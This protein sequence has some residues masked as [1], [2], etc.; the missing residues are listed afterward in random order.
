[1]LPKKS[2]HHVGITLATP[3]EMAREVELAIR[4]RRAA[5]S[6]AAI[7]VHTFIEAQRSPRYR[8]ALNDASIGWIDGVPI[9]WL[10]HA[11]GFPPPPRIHGADLFLLLLERLKDARHL[12]YGSTPETL[13]LLEQRLNERLPGIRTVGFI[14]PPFR[15]EASR[16]SPDLLDQLNATGAD[17]IWVALGAPKQ[18]LW[19]MLNRKGLRIPVIACVGAAFEI[20]AGRYS[21]A[22]LWLQRLGLEWLWRMLQN[23]ARLWRRYFST[24]GAFLALLLRTALFGAGKTSGSEPQNPRSPHARSGFG[25]PDA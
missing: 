24:N 22:P 6:L 9:R 18:E 14:S 12:F 5:S 15:K 7:N 11:G 17:V 13:R 21:R 3:E 2:L 23:P 20:H 1:M 10:V 19:A 16:E 25:G 8:D 4:E